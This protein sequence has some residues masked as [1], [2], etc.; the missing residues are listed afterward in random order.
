[1]APLASRATLKVH[2]KATLTLRQ[3]LHVNGPELPHRSDVWGNVTCYIA[4]CN[5]K[6]FMLQKSG[7]PL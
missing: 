1:M 3:T 6:V 5:V 2:S 7:P 4:L